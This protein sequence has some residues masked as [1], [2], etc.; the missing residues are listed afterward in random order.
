MYWPSDEANIVYRG[1]AFKN[2]VLE[3][4]ILANGRFISFLLAI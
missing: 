2:R 1:T 3:A 4:D